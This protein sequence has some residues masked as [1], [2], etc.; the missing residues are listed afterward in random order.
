MPLAPAVRQHA[1][2]ATA[3]EKAN[4][5]PF[6]DGLALHDARLIGG[7]DI[8][9]L[10][11]QLATAPA[12]ARPIITLDLAGLTMPGLRE[13]AIA[14]L[15]DAV[16]ELWPSAWGGEDF[17]GLRADAL[18]LAH[19]PIQLTSL[20]RRVPDLSQAWAQRAVKSLL[21]GHGPRVHA[22][23]D[24]EWQQLTLM[25]AP[26]GITLA[27]SL[28]PE[29][30]PIPFIAAVEWLAAR[31]AVAVIVLADALPPSLAPWARL[32]YGARMVA[33]GMPAP[34]P[35]LLPVLPGDRA[36]VILAAPAVEGRPHPLSA[37]ELRL[38]RFIQADPELGGLFGYNLLVDDTPLLH[39]KVDLLWRAGSVVVEVDGAEHRAATKYR[40]DRD[41]DHRLMCAGYRVLRLT[42]EEV[43]EDWGR[44][45]EKIREVVRLAERERA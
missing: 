45:V 43:L 24:L 9:D 4:L 15:A 22:S 34:D 13:S 10:R 32:L 30:P 23:P 31:A 5:P 20:A 28:D 26:A 12:V 8:A 35:S 44:A 19:L 6:V 17:A 3:L 18:S 25:L 41:R 16:G 11:E 29:R 27:V 14:Q 40:A 39:A 7:C 33:P 38:H 21:C 37:A 2:A 1:T 36:P 42:N